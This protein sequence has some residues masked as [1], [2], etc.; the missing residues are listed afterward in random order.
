MTIHFVYAGDPNGDR[1]CSPYTITQNLYRFL[2]SKAEVKYYDWTASGPIDVGPDDVFIGHPNYPPE[3]VTQWV[4]KN[5]KC[6]AKFLIHP[7]HHGD[8]QYN[9]PFSW[10]VDE[11]DAV[12][13]IMGPYW[14]DTI[15]TSAFASWH[16]KIIR[17]DMAVNADAYPYTKTTF[18]PPGRRNYVYVGSN[19]PMKNT[20]YLAKIMR[21]MPN[22]KLYWY[23]GDGGAELAKLPNVQTV[24]WVDVRAHREEICNAADIFVNVSYSDANPTTLLETTAWGL[25]PACTKE[26]GYYDDPMFTELYLD[27]F[28]GTLR[29]LDRL[30]NAPVDELISRSLNSRSIIEDHYNWKTFC[31]K[32]WD[33]IC[34]HANL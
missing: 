20:N 28:N 30:Q 31:T 13:S 19:M 17:L 14:Y 16:P 23:G 2:K 18:N 7:L 21:A 29:A 9:M 10:M 27:D 32:V 1:E 33:G 34:A 24:G 25:I 26:S 6:K 5:V 8:P 12:F 4:F 15:K 22:K 3:T 11:A